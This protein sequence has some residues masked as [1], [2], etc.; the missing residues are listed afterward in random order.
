MVIRRKYSAA[1]TTLA[2]VDA[3]ILQR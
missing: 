1:D 3:V 2:L